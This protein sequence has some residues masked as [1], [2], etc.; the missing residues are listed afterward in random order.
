[1]ASVRTLPVCGG[2]GSRHL[3]L[4]LHSIASRLTHTAAARRQPLYCSSASHAARRLPLHTTLSW[5]LAQLC[6]TVTIY[7]LSTTSSS[8]R[9][10]RVFFPSNLPCNCT[11]HTRSE[12]NR[13]LRRRFQYYKLEQVSCGC[14]VPKLDKWA[15]SSLVYIRV[16]S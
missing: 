6:L 11:E 16:Y 8:V 14:S 2:A 3:H 4:V 5:T 10:H 9:F 7:A 13:S 15:T 1:M 12:Q